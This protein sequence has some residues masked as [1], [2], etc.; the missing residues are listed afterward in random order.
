MLLSILTATGAIYASV[1][2][3]GATRP[4]W[5]IPINRRTLAGSAF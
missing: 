2:N 5:L 3:L 1:N 4:F